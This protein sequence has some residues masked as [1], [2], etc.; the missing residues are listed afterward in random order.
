MIKEEFIIKR[1]EI[2]E[3]MLDNPQEFGIYFTSKC[4][5]QLDDLYDK[6]TGC[7]VL[8]GTQKIIIEQELEEKKRMDEMHVIDVSTQE[9]MDN[10]L[11]KNR[12]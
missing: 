6:I 4:F 3:N 12:E 2:I 8:S 1:T 5:A 11:Y 10:F 9:K 7:N